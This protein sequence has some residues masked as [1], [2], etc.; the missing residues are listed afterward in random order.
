MMGLLGQN[1]IVNGG[2]PVN[3]LLTS[4]GRKEGMW[5]KQT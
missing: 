4:E 1:S 2:A 5:R 3:I